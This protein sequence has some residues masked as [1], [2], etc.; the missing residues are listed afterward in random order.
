[1]NRRSSKT[2]AT[3]RLNVSWTLLGHRAD[4]NV[5]ELDEPYRLILRAVLRQT[6]DRAAT[7][8]TATEKGSEM[9]SSS[10]IKYLFV[11]VVLWTLSLAACQTT[12]GKKIF[13]TPGGS[14]AI[15][16]YDSVAYFRAKTP[17]KGQAKFHHS[18]RG[19]RWHFSSAENRDAFRTSPEEFAPQY[20]GYCAWAVSQ[21]YTAE[22]DPHA[23]KV[24]N[25]KLYLNYSPSVQ[26]T[27]EE[28]IP[29]NVQKADAHWPGIEAEL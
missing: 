29:G 5:I 26:T 28:D 14:V 16:G 1:M 4:R 17:V 13:A 21:G 23:W 6:T 18:W 19:V 12:A 9:T 11:G 10:P 7:D 2:P 25:G 20:G 22:T 3:E 15:A 24:V 27:W 8:K